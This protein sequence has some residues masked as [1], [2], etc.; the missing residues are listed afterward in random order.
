M[1]ARGP[2]LRSSVDV[3]SHRLLPLV[4]LVAVQI[5]VAVGVVSA[6]LMGRPGW[7]GAVVG[8]VVSAA[9]VAPVRGTNAARSIA[10]RCGY[11]MDR[12]RRPSRHGDAEPFDVT[13]ADGEQI[14]FRWDGTTLLSV[15]RIDANPQ[16]LTVMEPGVTVSGE[17][18]RVGTLVECLEQFDIK[19]DAIDI[20]SHGARSHG[21][22]AIAAVY[23]AVLGP[24]PAIAN[25]TVWIALRFDPSRCPDAVRRRGGGR[26][27]VIRT[28][29]TATRRVAN[30]LI[31]AGLRP[32]ILTASGI[33][34]AAN[35]LADGVN[36]STVEETWEDCRD[37]Q[38]RLCSFAI[39]PELLT[40]EGLGLLW[41]VPSYS[42]TLCLS[43]REH[44]T[45][46]LIRVRGL[47]RF[48]GDRTVPAALPGL[49][50]L[51]GLQFSALA[52][53]LPVPPPARQIGHWNYG[54]PD[55]ELRGL[56]VPASGC[57][58]VIG[59]DEQGR[60]VALPVFGPQISRVEICGT[61]HLAQQAVL[62]A[63]A[64][65]ARVLVHSRRAQQWR[66]M[67]EV[68]AR[69]DLLW[70]PDFNRGAMQAGS[71]RNYNVEVF[72]GVSEQSVR[73]GVTCIVVVPPG[74]PA[75]PDADVALELISMEHDTVKVST[76][77]GAAIVTMVATD[78]EMRYLR[79]SADSFD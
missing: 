46:G 23:D 37:G 30:R 32:R 18:V 57:G 1:S 38:F 75:S 25:R 43:L 35:Q 3:G 74:T 12:R 72:D 49:I 69:Q 61:L 39:A 29:T 44:D 16:A 73:A 28:A 13:A 68:I 45:E 55:L 47:A 78:E 8:L 21:H 50:P 41:T 2:Q 17:M 77:S 40:T 63:L 65:G 24:L 58:Q 60:A 67:V 31:E 27:G 54:R 33:A 59:A 64:L 26:E 15:I 34:A 76:R 70:V 71:E 53:T 62:R 7:Q 36:P 48:D 14:G 11:A 79:A 22:T 42:T 4:D 51:R 56:A 20:I 9:F 19:L 52:S 6:S 66:D 10:L 5:V